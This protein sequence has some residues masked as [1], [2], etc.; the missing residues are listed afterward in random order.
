MARGGARTLT[1]TSSH[2]TGRAADVVVGDGDQSR[3]ATRR[4]WVAFRRLAQA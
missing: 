2:M 3:A 4:Q 1:L